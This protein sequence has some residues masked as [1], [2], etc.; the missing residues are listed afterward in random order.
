[1]G[2][3]RARRH[4]CR[5]NNPGWPSEGDRRRP[6]IRRVSIDHQ[7]LRDKTM[8]F[9]IFKQAVAAKWER[10]QSTGPVFRTAVTGDE[11]WTTYLDSFPA[12]TNLVYRERREYDCS[13]CRHFV[14]NIGNAVAFNGKL[15]SIWD[16][17]VAEP[18]FQMVAD[19]MAALVRR[20]IERPFLHWERTAGTDKNF[21][22][23]LEPVQ[24]VK[25]WQHFFVNLRPDM[26]VTRADI[27]SKLSEQIS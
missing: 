13:C 5:G 8:D 19:A 7:K 14:K 24:S 15:M 1:M 12:G 6:G 16:I 2:R 23:I 4:R 17:Q 26:V 27:P 9:N 25:T 22:Q 21:E 3:D 18:A 20:K 10:M 11:L